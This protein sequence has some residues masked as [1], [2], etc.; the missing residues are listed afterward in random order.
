MLAMQLRK[1]AIIFFYKSSGVVS[2]RAATS[3]LCELG[4]QMRCGPACRSAI[5]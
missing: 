4:V 2:G 3:E 1:T 5:I